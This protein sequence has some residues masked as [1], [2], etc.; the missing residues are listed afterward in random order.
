MKTSPIK[1]DVA[2]AINQNMI[3]SATDIEQLLNYYGLDDDIRCNL[4]TGIVIDI[5]PESYEIFHLTTS[6]FWP[7]I[8]YLIYNTT[9]L[10]WLLEMLNT[11][12]TTSC[13]GKIE[14]PA[15]IVYIPQAREI[16][17]TVS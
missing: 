8:S 16:I 11:T 7:Q 15:H 3:V 6:M 9:S 14:A 4:N 10:Y 1:I 5:D 2:T 12:L 17:S 13:F